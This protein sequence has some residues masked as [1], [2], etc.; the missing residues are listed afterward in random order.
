ML[1]AI[2]ECLSDEQPKFTENNYFLIAV[3]LCWVCQDLKVCSKSS[4]L[5]SIG[6]L[7]VT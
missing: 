7:V 3:A 1:A 6:P 4:S 2:D 5:K